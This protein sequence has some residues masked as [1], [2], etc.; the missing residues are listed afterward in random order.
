MIYLTYNDQPSGIYN[1]QVIDVCRFLKDEFNEDIQLIALVSIR[2][3]ALNRKK[4]KQELPNALVVPMIPKH[5]NWKLNLSLL[6]LLFLFLKKGQKMIARG[7]FSTNLALD[8][9]KGGLVSSVVFDARGAY[10]A[11]FSEYLHKVVHLNDDISALEARAVNESDFRLAVSG[12]LVDHWR[13]AYSYE[14]TR[15]VVIPCTLSNLEESKK[16]DEIVS[17][18]KKMG[19]QTGDIILVYAGST[20]DWQSSGMINNFLVDQLKSNSAIKVLML[21]RFNLNEFGANN[22]FPGRITQLWLPASEVPL[23]LAIADYGLLIREQSVTNEVASPTKFAEYLSAGLKVIISNGIGDFP[24][25]VKIHQ[26][27]SIYTSGVVLPL[28]IVS[29]EE[30]RRMKTLATEYF[31][32]KHFKNEFKKIIS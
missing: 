24:E 21:S 17:F 31:H 32:K 1:S 19:Y 6:K 23:Y 15:H 12:K 27:G 29:M 5:S 25:F 10:Q 3:F 13:R 7:V 4:I 8:L 16:E 20:A 9:K 28:E 14:G 11:E 30:K 2:G 22:L 26:A 18:R